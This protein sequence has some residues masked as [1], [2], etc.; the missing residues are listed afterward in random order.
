M[1]VR[2]NKLASL[3]ALGL[4]GGLALSACGGGSSSSSSSEGSD[5]GGAAGGGNYAELTGN[6][7]GSGASSM[8]NAQTAWTES[9][10]GLVGAEGG[11]LQVTYDP[12]GSGTGREQFLSGQ[13]KFAGTDAALDEEV[14]D[15]VGRAVDLRVGEPG[16][17]QDDGLPVAVGAGTLL[18]Q[19]GQ[20]QHGVPPGVSG[21]CRDLGLAVNL[22]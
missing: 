10:M 11:D 2:K 18:E 9:F 16:V 15:L 22:T 17:A 1:N 3:A 12:T 20:V 6:L 19:D 14:G 13:V 4:V 21:R 5:A 7:A 8:Q